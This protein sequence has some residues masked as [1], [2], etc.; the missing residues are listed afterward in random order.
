MFHNLDFDT[1]NGLNCWY[2]CSGQGCK[3]TRS[4]PERGKRVRSDGRLIAVLTLLSLLS[5][6]ATATANPPT[7]A[8]PNDPSEL[9][10]EALRDSIGHS[11]GRPGFNPAVDL[12]GDGTVNVLDVALFKLAQ[13][14]GRVPSRTTASTQTVAGTERI[15]VEAP[16]TTAFPGQTVSVLFL[17]RDNTTPLVGYSLEVAAVA[18]AGAVGSVTA[19]VTSTNFFDVQNLITACSPA[20]CPTGAIRDPLF[21]VIADNGSGGVTIDTLTADFST[22]LAVDGVNDVLAQVFFDVP[23]DALGDFTVQLGSSST[24]I[25]GNAVAVS[26]AFTPGTI[27]VLEP[28]TVPTVSEWGMFVMSVLIVTAGCVVLANRGGAIGLASGGC[29]PEDGGDAP[30]EM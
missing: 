23:L 28:A 15:I 8:L 21:S 12:N 3:F 9:T 24:L 11:A 29:S 20:I 10:A 26:F 5:V 19:D 6:T 14:E 17:L 4:H 30:P 25:D 18:D 16:I 7:P 27:R 2:A 22:V 13:R 1:R